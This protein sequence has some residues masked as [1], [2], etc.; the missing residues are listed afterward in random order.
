MKKLILALIIMCLLAGCKK[1]TVSEPT[2][3]A[4]KVFIRIDAL[5]ADGTVISSQITTVE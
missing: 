4:S 1:E 2:D 5:N 3:I